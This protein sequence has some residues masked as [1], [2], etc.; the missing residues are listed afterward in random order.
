[1][2]LVAAWV[3]SRQRGAEP[4]ETNPRCSF[5]ADPRAPQVA[6]L[7]LAADDLH[8]HGEPDGVRPLTSAMQ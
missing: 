1:M 3:E 6:E 2:R 7:A 5:E 4:S 8:K